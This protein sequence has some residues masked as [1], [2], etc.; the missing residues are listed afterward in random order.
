M[1]DEIFLEEK[2]EEV[3]ED[4]HKREVLAK[5][6]KSEV[7]RLIKQAN[8]EWD[9]A[10]VDSPDTPRMLPLIRLKVNYNQEFS[11]PNPQRLGQEF[12]GKIA[13]PKDVV[14]FVKRKIGGARKKVTIDAPGEI[15]MEVDEEDEADFDATQPGKTK[16]KMEDLVRSYLKE[17]KLAV[18]AEN[19]MQFAVEKFVEKDDR[20]AIKAFIKSTVDDRA[21]YVDNLEHAGGDSDAEIENEIVKGKDIQRERIAKAGGIE[22]GPVKGKGKAKAK[23]VDF[24]QDSDASIVSSVAAKKTTAKGKAKKKADSPDPFDDDEE[25]DDPPPKKKACVRSVLA[26]LTHTVLRRRLLPKRP[27][28][29]PKTPRRRSSPRS[30]SV[31]PVPVVRLLP[32]VRRRRNELWTKIRGPPIVMT[33]QSLT[34]RSSD[35]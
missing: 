30:T 9:E 18:I 32:R 15:E 13:N 24:D 5:F 1:T 10:H 16:L 28:R 35:D 2:H 3:K 34:S 7:N 25:E 6:L 29:R 33:R 27:R 12:A 26:V 20:D 23:V 31:A 21:Q 8:A 19:G 14:H 4:L 22:D 17:Q 11:A